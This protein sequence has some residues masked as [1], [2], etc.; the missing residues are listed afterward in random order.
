MPSEP[1]TPVDET[2]RS[3]DR[4]PGTARGDGPETVP[5]TDPDAPSDFARDAAPV[6]WGPIRFERLRSLALGATLV[7]VGAALLL[8]LGVA[9][10]FALSLPAG[11][12]IPTEASALVVLLFVG[13]PASLFYLL[14]AYDRA[15]PERRREL[16]SPLGGGSFDPSH[17]RLGWTLLGTGAALAVGATALGP[18]AWAAPGLAPLV[19][20][21]FAVLPALSRTQGTDVRLDPTELTVERTHRGRDRSR[22]DDLGSAVRTRRIDLPWTTVFLIAYRGNAWY[23]STPWLFVPTGLA[24]RVERALDEALARSDGPD[25]ASVP[26]RVTLAVVGSASLVVGLSMSLAAGEAA[27]G[28]LLTLLTAP[29]SLLFLALAAR[30]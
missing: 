2:G 25:R 6:E 1:S 15:S 23:R 10:A 27:A 16:L 19:V 20:S 5:G 26:E 9:V 22:T 12:G 4:E 13:G 24:D 18:G 3:A 30:L 29:F 8:A 7:A 17:F 21:L 28:L 11:G 14:I